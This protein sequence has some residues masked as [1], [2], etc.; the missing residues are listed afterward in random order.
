MIYTHVYESVSKAVPTGSGGGVSV[1]T[2]QQS[3]VRVNTKMP[4]RLYHRGNDRA[5][6]IQAAVQS[7]C[8]ATC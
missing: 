7:N 8:Q 1:L 4:F 3:R 6:I 2:G 5:Y